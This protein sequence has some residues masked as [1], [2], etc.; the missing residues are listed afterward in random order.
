MVLGLGFLPMR[1]EDETTDDRG[2][3]RERFALRSSNILFAGMMLIYVDQ[4]LSSKA[5][6]AAG[7]WEGSSVRLWFWCVIALSFCSVSR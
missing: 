7:Q 5:F 1:A 2:G 4:P 3:G 6:A